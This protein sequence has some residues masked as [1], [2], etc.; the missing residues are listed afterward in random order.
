M[1]D[2]CQ[3]ERPEPPEPPE[4]H[5]TVAALQFPYADGRVTQPLADGPRQPGAPI[6]WPMVMPERATQ[7]HLRILR[8]RLA[9]AECS[10]SP[11]VGYDVARVERSEATFTVLIVAEAKSWVERIVMA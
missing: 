6:A 5:R 3:S 9:E 2:G 11:L 8:R 10:R 1:D 7:Y 4:A